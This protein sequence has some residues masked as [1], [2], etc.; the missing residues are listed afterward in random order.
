M[1]LWDILFCGET[2]TDVET[3][4]K[5]SDFTV[6]EINLIA[7]HKRKE[8]SMTIQKLIGESR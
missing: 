2:K 6:D 4:M 3:D 7:I 1:R 5:I 8:R